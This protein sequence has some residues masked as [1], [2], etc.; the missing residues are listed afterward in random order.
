MRVDFFVVVRQVGCELVNEHSRGQGVVSRRV[1]DLF[2]LVLDS[3][4][5]LSD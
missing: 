5:F 2:S 1:V 3:A 4:N